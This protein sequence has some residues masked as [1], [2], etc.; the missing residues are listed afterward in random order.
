MEGDE[1]MLMACGICS[2]VQSSFPRQRDKLPQ[3]RK[4]NST[5]YSSILLCILAF[6][7]STIVYIVIM[8]PGFQLSDSD[9]YLGLCQSLGGERV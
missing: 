4:I 6:A 8:S 7:F 1:E 2:R 5:V 9:Y 3:K